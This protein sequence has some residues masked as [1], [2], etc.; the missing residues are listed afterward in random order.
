M[1][2][3]M[4]MTAS[5]PRLFVDAPL[6]ADRP[7]P[8]NPGQGHYLSNVM[9]LKPG[10]PIRVFNGIDG[11]W[12]ATLA[13][14]GKSASALPVK[15][16]RPQQDEPDLWLVFA[17]IKGHRFD[18]IVEK[19]T[20]LGVAVLQPVVTRHTIVNRINAER[21]RAHA[22]EAAEQS[23]RLSVPEVRP[24]LPLDRA[25]ADW[26]ADRVLVH[27]DESGGGPPLPDVAADLAGRKLAL[28]VGPEG[29]FAKSELD[30]LRALAFATAVGLGP[31]ILRADTAAIAAAAVLLAS[32]GGWSV[33]PA[34]R[35]RE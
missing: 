1:I 6:T 7:F 20:E 18:N 17:P 13:T 26:P 27:L 32:T 15:P 14:T 31:R 35:A 12:E 4:T 24:L 30:A 3:R 28:L 29:G 10:A 33:A 22:V 16:L 2:R 5:L 8:L 34:F 9:R 21:M 25:L 19:A 11:E 23:E